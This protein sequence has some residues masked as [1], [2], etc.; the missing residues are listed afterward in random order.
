VHGKTSNPPTPSRS[1]GRNSS[2]ARAAALAL[3]AALAASCG[4]TSARDA[5]AHAVAARNAPNV[6]FVCIDT[7]RADRLGCYGYARKTSP[8]LD[9][10]AARGL[11]F[12]RAY[13]TAPWT[14]PATTSLM[15]GLLPDL[16]RATNF[17]SPV[18]PDAELLAQ[19]LAAAGYETAAF[20]G[21]Y[22][23]QPIFGLARGFAAYNG[24]CTVDRTGVNSDK[25]SDRAV[26]WLAAPHEKPFFL[27]LHYFDP[28]YNYIEH[29]GFTFGGEDTDKVFSGADIFDLRDAL[30][31]FTEKDKFRLDSLYDSEVAFTD[32]HLGRVLDK[33]DELKLSATT[34][35][36]ATAD[37]GEAL[38]EHQWIGHTVQLYEEA[39]RVPLILAGPGITP[40]VVPAA[41]LRQGDEV[42]GDLLA[43]LGLKAPAPERGALGA[44][45][46]LAAV[47]TVGIDEPT[48][49]KRLRI[50]KKDAWKLFV[51]RDDQG[52]DS[53]R[54]FKLDEPK[55]QRKK[56]VADYPEVLK[57][58]LA[59]R[60]QI[61]DGRIKERERHAK[62][63]TRRRAL[64]DGRFKLIVDEVSGESE[65]YDL[66]KDPH[67]ANDL[68][69]ES[70]EVVAGMKS[71]LER[72]FP[73]C[74]AGPGRMRSRF[75]AKRSKPT[76]NNWKLRATPSS[77]HDE[78][79]PP[80][81]PER[82]GQRLPSR[83]PRRRRAAAARE[84]RDAV[85]A[86]AR[87][88]V[89]LRRLL[90]LLP[91]LAELRRRPRSGLQPRRPRRGLHQLPVGR[92][93]RRRAQARLRGGARV[94]LARRRVPDRRARA[95]VQGGAAAL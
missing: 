47:E 44:G 13:A 43:R 69:Q 38:G 54:L 32:H 39:L 63:Q 55:G 42:E 52:G 90:H 82:T 24:E 71:R 2:I 80:H 33:L 78:R 94:A 65:L 35:V 58:M 45:M 88:P 22:F 19:H 50:L 37:H 95:H 73:T 28:H 8:N 34:L 68:S 83:Q 3:L 59:T 56:N 27:Y 66:E 9:R 64:I 11:R 53:Y 89:L 57:E 51:D 93:D 60:E 84:R 25:I 72:S 4:P 85:V 91:L 14:L 1:I 76:A 81:G 86:R 20:V 17:S 6:L 26:A 36:V 18:S 61:Y 30:K 48:E 70:K 15:T 7:L 23:V 75:P 16:H 12:E 5:A 40:A 67:E 62:A 87:A 92:P 79:R 31:H 10:L 29:D 41:Q 77:D 21:N 49:I 46:A 74:A